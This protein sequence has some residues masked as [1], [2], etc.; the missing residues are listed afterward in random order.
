[1]QQYIGD[2]NDRSVLVTEVT[3]AL[4]KQLDSHVMSS[5]RARAR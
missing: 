2:S 4:S 1:V 3:E 5:P